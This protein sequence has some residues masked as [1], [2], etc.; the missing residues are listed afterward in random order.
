[1]AYWRK[2]PIL[3]AI[4]VLELLLLALA[5]W[6]A[7]QPPVSYTFTPEQLENIAGE[8]VTLSYDENGYYGATYDIDWTE[9][10]QTPALSL[11][12]GH[13]DVSLEY[14]YRPTRTIDGQVHHSSIQMRDER[15]S[16]A[17]EPDVL[18]LTESRNSDT[19]MIQVR[20]QT[21]TA[22][23]VFVDDGGT[24]TVGSV[25]ITQNRTYTVFCALAMLLAFL[26]VDSALLLCLPSSPWYTGSKS[27][28]AGFALAGAVLLASAPSLCSGIPLMQ[29]DCR[30]HLVRIEGIAA[31][32]R[33]GQFPVRVNPIAKGDFGYSTSLFYGELFLYLPAV[34]RLL[35]ATVTQA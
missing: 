6:E 18:I 22:H 33:N 35:G 5:V 16:Y 34:L 23:L 28:F 30:F 24:F 19:L 29:D 15:N 27:V 8:G 13:Y 25:A 4:L 2:V 21:D 26:A 20:E 11:K 17:L 31:S 9:I 12:P 14:S 7:V 10:L 32:L 1:M 3:L